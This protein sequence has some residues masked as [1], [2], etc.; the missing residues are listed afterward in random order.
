MLDDR[1]NVQV[2]EGNRK[3]LFIYLFPELNIFKV[4]GY[5]FYL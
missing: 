2:E 4:K 5:K 1:N 3:D